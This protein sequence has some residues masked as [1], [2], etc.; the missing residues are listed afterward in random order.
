MNNSLVHNAK[1]S[2]TNLKG[3]KNSLIFLELL[4]KYFRGKKLIG[5]KRR[6]YTRQLFLQFVPQFW[7][8]VGRQAALNVPIVTPL[9]NAGKICCSVARIAAK[10]RSDFYFSQRLR[11]QKKLQD[12]FISGYVTLDNFSCNFY[13]NKTARQVPKKIA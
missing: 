12:M 5:E 8:A 13:Q 3:K 4:A 7:C 10:S 6:C 9:S 11:H 2:K 1:T